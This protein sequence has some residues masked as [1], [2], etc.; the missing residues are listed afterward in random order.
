VI[1]TNQSLKVSVN[2]KIRDVPIT[3]VTKCEINKLFAFYLFTKEVVT[4]PSGHYKFYIGEGNNGHL[5]TRILK[6][7]GWWVPTEDIN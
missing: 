1:I 4:A 5:I 7:R 2:W 3:G 6:S